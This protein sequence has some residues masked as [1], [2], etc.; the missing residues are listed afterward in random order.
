MLSKSASTPAN[1]GTLGDTGSADSADP[2]WVAGYVEPGPP[3]NIPPVAADDSADT[4]EDTAVT[5]DVL[6]NDSDEDGDTLTVSSVTQPADG[7]V[8]NNGTD[9]TYTPDADYCGSDS[10]T[11]TVSDG[12]GGSDTAAVD[13]S[14]TCVNDAPVAADDSETTD[15]DTSVT[16]D[17]LANDTDVDGDSLSVDS[18][19]QP[20]NGTVTNNV[21]D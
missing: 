14:V 15:E 12:N 3:D 16:I 8:V 7:T 20:T 1:D 2:T 17:V 18:V 11:Y 9:V 5:I 19:T 13:V 4:D 21:I 10:F 6:T